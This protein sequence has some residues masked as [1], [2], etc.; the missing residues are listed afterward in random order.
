MLKDLHEQEDNFIELA[1]CHIQDS[2]G[3]FR[4]EERVTFLHSAFDS[5]SKARDEFNAKVRKNVVE[6]CCS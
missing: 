1:H 5:F 4:A 6:R 2:L 3:T